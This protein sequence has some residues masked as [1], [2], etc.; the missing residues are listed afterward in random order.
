VV[1]AQHVI[2][3]S[4]ERRRSLRPPPRPSLIPQEDRVSRH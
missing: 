1:V 2:G 3:R 4:R